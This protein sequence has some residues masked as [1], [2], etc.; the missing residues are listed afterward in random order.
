M[1]SPIE[2]LHKENFKLIQENNIKVGSKFILNETY[3]EFKEGTE[4][5][6]SNIHNLYGWILFEE[7]SQL[8]QIV[9]D[10]L[11]LGVFL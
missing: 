8:P 7:T 5:K 2:L 3:K 1:I 6:V 11:N 10:L 4:F 9:Y